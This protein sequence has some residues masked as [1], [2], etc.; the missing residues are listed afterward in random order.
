MNESKP[1]STGNVLK[2]KETNDAHRSRLLNAQHFAEAEAQDRHFNPCAP[3]A[4]ERHS[5]C[6]LK[7]SPSLH[8][9]GEGSAGEDHRT[10]RLSGDAE[11]KMR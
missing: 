4:Y 1:R 10:P 7:R 6:K 11:R 9:T 8:M 5:T 2:L 3:V